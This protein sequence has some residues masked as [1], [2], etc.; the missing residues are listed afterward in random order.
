MQTFKDHVDGFYDVGNQMVD[1]IRRRAET[2]FRRRDEERKALTTL[3]AVEAHSEQMRARFLEG[4]GGLPTERTPLNAR[5]TGTVECDGY[6]LEKIIYESLPGFPVTAACYVPDSAQG[7]TPTVIVV[8]G[9]ANEGKGAEGYQ[10][11]AIDLVRNGFVVF[12]IDPLGQGERSQFFE[13][14]QR[15]LGGCTTE[16]TVAGMQFWAHGQSIARHF[17]WDIVRGIDYLEMRPEVDVA[18][19]GITGS[20]GGGTQTMYAMMSDP[21]IAAAVP[22]TFVM[23]LESYLKT[24][25]PQDAEQIVQG[26]M[27]DG[28]DHDDYLIAFAPKPV[29]LGTAAYDFFPIEGTY[30]ALNRAKPIYELYGKPDNVAMAVADHTHAYS[31]QLREACVNWFK[32]HFRGETPDFRTSQMPVLPEAQTWATVSG[33]VNVDDPAALTVFDF[34]G[35][36]VPQ[37]Q[38]PETVD[39]LRHA[40]GEALGVAHGG[41]RDAAIY[42]RIIS[43]KWEEGY[44]A[45]KLFFFSTTDIVVTGVMVHPRRVKAD[46]AVPTTLMLLENG[47]NDIPAVRD[48][49]EAM[50]RKGERVL[51]YDVRGIG[52]VAMRPFN[53][54]Q[55]WPIFNLEYKVGCDAMML[56]LSTVGLRVFDVLRGYDYLR[57]RSDVGDVKLQGVGSGAIFAFFAAALEEGIASLT[58]EDLL[59]SY[60][61]SCETRFYNSLQYNL[62]VLVPGLLQHGDLVDFLPCITPRPVE[63]SYLR[64]AHGETVPATLLLPKC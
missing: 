26:C 59:Y 33:Q 23:T 52:A 50:L 31:P 18:R 4:I 32:V 36:D 42:P 28:P 37:Q 19:I 38:W 12:A 13:D 48:R 5:V 45:E 24:G 41:D 30:E 6:R 14:G 8:H 53:L 56:G 44:R 3:S 2:H 15:V 35:A 54:Y 46:A 61:N 51:V 64:N 25:Q 17:T 62:K 22:C 10:R 1:D 55:E 47:T 43:D 39:E 63:F 7:P 27:A 11:V 16:H 58:C 60:R 34:V 9:H 21:R 29:L 57:T 20:S 49:I 40:L